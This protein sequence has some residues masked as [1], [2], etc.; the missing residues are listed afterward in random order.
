MLRVLTLVLTFLIRLRFPPRLGF[1]DVL[2]KRYGTDSLPLYRNLEKLDFKLKKTNL[3]L[4]F[5]LT[6]KRHGVIPK[7][8]YFKTYSR[9]IQS[10]DM[11]KSFQ[12]RLLDH[13]IKQKQRLIRTTQPKLDLAYNDFKNRVSFFDFTILYCRLEQANDTK[14]HNTSKTPLKK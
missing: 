5:L 3:D 4:N 9:N 11:Y 7:F 14:C 10:T 6:C 13:E 1:V 2:T 12:F 8:L